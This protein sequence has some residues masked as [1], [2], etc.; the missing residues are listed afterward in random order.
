MFGHVLF[1]LA[2]SGEV[3]ANGSGVVHPSHCLRRG[4]AAF[5]SGDSKLRRLQWSDADRVEVRFR[6]QYGDRAQVGNVVVGTRSEVRGPRSG[7]GEGGAAVVPTVALMSCHVALP[8]HAP[9]SSCR[10]GQQVRAWGYGQAL[11]A[12]GDVV[13]ESGRKPE[14]CAL[15]SVRIESASTL[16]VGSDVSEP[17]MP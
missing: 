14:E 5:F 17:V 7:V 9:L 2:R 16:A 1:S 15:H 13:S 4:D 6:G 11:K 3:F 8:E 12:L 10:S